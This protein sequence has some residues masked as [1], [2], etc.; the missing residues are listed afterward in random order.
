M[1]RLSSAQLCDVN[2][3]PT[4]FQASRAVRIADQ[5]FLGPQLLGPHCFPL[6]GA[7]LILRRFV[8][9]VV[10]LQRFKALC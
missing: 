5:T 4:E 3:Q 9:P 2:Q 1:R 10:F 7:R 8:V 6:Y